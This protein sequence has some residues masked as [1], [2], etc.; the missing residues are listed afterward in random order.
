MS[1]I[2]I[3]TLVLLNP[4]IRCLCKQC[5]SRSINLDLHCLLLSIW[6]YSNN[7]DQAI[8]LAEIGSGCGI[9]IYSTWQRLR[10]I[11][12]FCRAMLWAS[13]VAQLKMSQH[14]EQRLPTSM[15]QLKIMLRMFLTEQQTTVR[16]LGSMLDLFYF[17]LSGQFQQTTNRLYFSHFSQKIGF[18]ISC[19]LSP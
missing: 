12:C 15:K 19:K 13:S 5:R 9:L 3:L 11:V 4:D 14:M 8:W 6:I 7:P 17:C 18:D 10:F 1:I 16:K 2:K